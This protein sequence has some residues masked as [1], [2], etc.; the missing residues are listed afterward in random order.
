MSGKPTN[1]DKRKAYN[2]VADEYGI[3]KR[4]KQEPPLAPIIPPKSERKRPVTQGSASVPKKPKVAQQTALSK[5]PIASVTDIPSAVLDRAGIKPV[6]DGGQ[7]ITELVTGLLVS[8]G[9]PAEQAPQILSKKLK[10]KGITLD[11]PVTADVSAATAAAK[12]R[13]KGMS[14]QWK[15]MPNSVRKQMG[16]FSIADEELEYV[17]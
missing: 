9:T 13:R 14:K 4:S 17:I 7:Y 12:E 16:M 8:G 6:G 10:G 15:T 5:Q 3:A 2:A 11:N 1:I